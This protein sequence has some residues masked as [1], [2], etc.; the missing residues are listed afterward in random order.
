M[1]HKL[2]QSVDVL[3]GI[4]EETANQL[5]ALD[6]HTINDLLYHFPYRH[7]DMRLRDLAEVQHNEK[8][9]VEGQVHSEPAL[10]YYGRKRSRLLIQLLVGRY[11]IKVTFFNRPYLK[12]KISPQD[13]VTVFGT[14]DKHRQAITG[15]DIKIGN[16]SR[17]E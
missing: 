3:T 8:V 5:A 4:G 10:I 11:L 17:N 7:E 6:I 15:Q 9:T 2:K 14:Y 1:N 16:Q 12:T 13:T